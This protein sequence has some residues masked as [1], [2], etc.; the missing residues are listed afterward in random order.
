MHRI[1]ISL[2]T[3]FSL[4]LLLTTFAISQE[5]A[6]IFD[7]NAVHKVYIEI[8]SDSLD[9]I[10]QNV[11]SN[12]EYPATFI[13]DD[14]VVRDTVPNIGFRLRGNTSR[15]SQKKSFKVS[16]N[17]FERGRKYQ[18]VEKLNLN[19]EHNDP[20]ILRARVCWDI[21]R[22][23]Q[24]PASR[25]NHMELYIN[26]SYYGLYLNVE[27]IDENF[28][29][30]IFGNNN[31]NLYKCLWPATLTF[32]GSGDPE[33]Y[34]FTSGGRRAYDLKTNTEGDD[35][36][37][38]AYFISVLNN[39]PDPFF[40]SSIQEVFN[41]N[42]YLRALAVDVLIANWD[43]YW[44]NKN[45]FYLYRNT[46]T[47][48]FEYIPYDLDNTLGIWWDGIEP[49]VDWG[50]RN[51]YDWGRD[52]AERPLA[53]RLLKFDVFRDRFSF[54]MD[55]LLNSGFDVSTLSTE[56]AALQTMITPAAELDTW[57]TL[58]YGF[59][60]ADFQNSINQ[61]VANHVPYGIIPY[62][63]ARHASAGS[64]LALNPI[65]PIIESVDRDPLWPGPNVDIK[66]YARVEDEDTPAEVKLE[67]ALNDV[68]QPA[69]EMADNGLGADL[70][71]NDK[72][73]SVTV[74]A[75]GED[76]RLN[77]YIVASDVDGLITSDPASAPANSYS[78]QSG[79]QSS[80]LFINEFMASNDSTIADPQG[81]YEDWLEIFNGD[82]GAVWLG[83]LYLTDNPDN[84]LKWQ[85]PPISLPS[86]DFLL[87][88]ADEDGVDGDDHANFRL[89]REGEFIG[90]LRSDTT[91]IDSISYGEQQT[92]ISYGR[93]T[94]GAAVWQEF[95]DPTPGASNSTTSIQ[96]GQDDPALQT[97]FLG[98]NYPNPF[99]GETIIPYSLNN[100]ADIELAIVN[101]LGQTIR[102]L[103]SGFRSAGSYQISW[104]G[105]DKNQQMVASGLYF[106]YL[107]AKNDSR[108]AMTQ[109]R[110]ILVIQ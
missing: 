77:Y 4:S 19:G 76:T 88:W 56:I 51:I 104:D 70:I 74:P 21:H 79:N 60:I 38:L 18:G 64:Q 47:G 90:L 100:N 73:Y 103:T 14:G 78:T 83:D 66:I 29:K 33:E 6:S 96:T 7:T 39:V 67:Y 22:E 110:K 72:V 16:F 81:D 85:L 95:P 106:V 92:D 87:I 15:F 52:A 48:K 43:G 53:E 13:F 30:R 10:F 12:Q 69:L 28:V 109:V 5:A 31:G 107:K 84:L 2:R 37:D 80:V 102:S 75:L 101:P 26:D 20:S 9:L 98:Q 49:G 94:D 89:N 25:T 36:S 86:G 55:Q 63:T 17:T 46:R 44:Y 68:W 42:G 24:V 62:L 61:S 1:A 108:P 27:H 105:R 45:N 3:F 82:T 99:N 8:E 59:T 58:D 54:Y 34:Q 71:A 23:F 11:E 40:V 97:F 93:V 57:R 32:R 41:V 50:N 65:A 35:Y 91:F